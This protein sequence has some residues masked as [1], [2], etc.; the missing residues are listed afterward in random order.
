[1]GGLWVMLTTFMLS[2]NAHFVALLAVKPCV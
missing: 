2:D 1:M